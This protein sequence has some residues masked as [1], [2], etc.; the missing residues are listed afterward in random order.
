MKRRRKER[1]GKDK[2]EKVIKMAGEYQDNK[3]NNME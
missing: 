3:E 1:V 2:G